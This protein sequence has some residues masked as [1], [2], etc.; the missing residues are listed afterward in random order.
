MNDEAKEENSGG[1]LHSDDM[2]EIVR[3]LVVMRPL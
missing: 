1:F 2:P 3:I